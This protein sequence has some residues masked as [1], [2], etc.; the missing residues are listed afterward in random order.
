MVPELATGATSELQDLSVAVSAAA[1]ELPDR[2]FVVGIG[3]ADNVIGPGAVGTF[4][5]YGVDVRV[6]LS[7]GAKGEPRPL[8]LCA[9]VAAWVRTNHSPA[10]SG[11]VW[12]YAADH[13]LGP[14]LA[15]GRALR[16]EVDAISEPV[17]VLV[18]ADGANTL[19]ASAPGGYDPESVVVQ[20]A[21]DDA[22]SAGDTEALTR[23]PDAI[24]GRVAY[25]VLA[26][27]IGPSPSSA[28][29]LYRGAPY[30]VGYS[31]DVWTP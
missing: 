27:L 6:A 19:I 3:V 24:V 9:L 30:G 25:Q 23:L 22:L 7:P 29:E 13:E 28:R 10:A 18:V 11:E 16:A 14:A 12:V 1:A 20:G 5:G 8:P 4:G 17:G 15:R 26:G 21:L 2:W 31:V